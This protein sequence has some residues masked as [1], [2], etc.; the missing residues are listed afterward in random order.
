LQD[1][2]KSLRYAVHLKS[3]AKYLGLLALVLACLALVPL[4]VSLWFGEYDLSKRYLLVILLLIMAGL[5]SLR[6]TYPGDLQQNESLAITALA[7]IITPL[8]MSYPLMGSGLDFIDAWFEA[9]SA[10]TTTGLSTVTNVEKMPHT[11]L[12]AR[13]WMQ[14]YGGLGIVVFSVAILLNHHIAL[15][16]LITPDTEGML[17]TTRVYTRRVFTVYIVLTL[18]GFIILLLLLGNGFS[19]IVYTL[20]AVSTGGFAPL[21]SSLGDL[22]L[23]A[24]YGISLL[25]LCG[26]IPL[27]F[28]YRLTRG[29]W[30]EIYSDTE[31]RILVGFTLGLSLLL[32]L[33][34][35]TLS[36]FDWR[37]AIH[38]GTLLAISAQTTTG[39]AS[40]DVGSLEGLTLGFM[41]FAMVIG[42]TAGST[43]GG[44]KI[45]R[46]LIMWSMIRLLI[47]RT[48]MTAHAV[49]DPRLG[50]KILEQE[51]IERAL[52]LIILFLMVVGISWLIFLAYGFDPLQALFEVASAAG[53]VGLSSGVT[54]HELDPFLKVVLCVNMLLGRVE[55]IAVLVVLYPGTWLGKRVE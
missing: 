12:F 18:A 43:A 45:L 27:I 50:D 44:F 32:T 10:V 11:F 26:A 40:L 37:D 3:L 5:P 41:I 46:L 47:Q 53:T 14:W 7:F 13:A 42:G 15:R 1:T 2:L 9:V 36:G 49:S 55:I 54:S 34:L 31:V 38:H 4:M 24:Q 19:A 29:D 35:I 8:I 39:F 17:T 52:M 6:L 16:R 30:R 28:Y 33:S 48:A 51:E 22:S 20:A 21:N 23:P 25:G